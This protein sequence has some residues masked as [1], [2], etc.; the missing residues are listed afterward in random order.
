MANLI[1]LTQAAE[2]LGVS[3][4]TLRKVIRKHDLVLFE[5]QLD[6][7]EKLIDVDKLEAAIRPVPIRTDTSGAEMGK[8]AA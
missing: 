7:R 1:P 4:N 6:A 8:A 5:N 3:M 2:R